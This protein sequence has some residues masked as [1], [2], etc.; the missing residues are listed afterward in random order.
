MTEKE[1]NPLRASF[2]NRA[3]LYYLIFDEMR[4]ELGREKAEDILKRAV[5]RRGSAIGQQFAEYGPADLEGLREAFLA[6]IPEDG[7]MFDP[8]VRRCDAAGLDIDLMSCPLKDA[9]QE[10]GLSD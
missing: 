8:K 7:K 3:M 5:Y 2:K 9:W 6:I 10:A 1:D 4:G